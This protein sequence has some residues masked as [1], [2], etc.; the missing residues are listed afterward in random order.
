MPQ[1]THTTHPKD[2]SLVLTFTEEDHR[3]VDSNRKVYTSVTTIAGEQFEQFDAPKHAERIAK[4]ENTIAQVILD[5]WSAK[6]D[7]ACEYGTRCHELAE[8][9]LTAQK[10]GQ[11]HDPSDAK[12][13]KA[14]QSIEAA[15]RQLS[16]WFE[17]V[18][19]EIVLFSP[20]ALMA[21]T[22]DLL[23]CAR[24][25][26]YMLLDWK[27]NERHKMF[28]KAY[29][30]GV[31]VCSD[32]PDTAIGHYSLQLSIYECLLRSEGHIPMNAK[33]VRAL[34]YVEPFS[35]KPIWVP[36]EFKSE[37]I[38]LINNNITKQR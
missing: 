31:G 13:F 37:A 24:D 28:G 21:G 34:L 27:T 38:T 14:F 18:Q 35:T 11:D 3:Y 29:R 22:C 8:S 16:Q 12:E 1:T 26:T 10:S 23:M 6:A 36:I 7:R 2:K 33:V 9:L 30:N 15:C 20:Q 19:C 25:G 17:L 5:R 4:K 32:V